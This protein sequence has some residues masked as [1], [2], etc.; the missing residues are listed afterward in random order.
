MYDSRNKKHLNNPTLFNLKIHDVCIENVS[1]QKL[2]GVYID[3]N[4]SWS[5][6]TDHLCSV[7]SSKISLLKQL[8]TYVPAELQKQFYQG[9]ILFLIDYGSNTWGTNSS[10]NIERLTKLRKRAA[11]IIL[12]VD[13]ATPSAFLFE[14]LGWLPVSKRI[15]Y[16]KAILT[17]K[18]L[19]NL[20]PEYITDLLE[21]MSHIYSVNLR[22]SENGTIHVP[23]L[24]TK[25]YESSFLCSAP[26][27]WNSLP[28]SVRN[29]SSLNSFKPLLVFVFK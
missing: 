7:I 4:L 8:A 12:K 15:K 11:R 2:L 17:Y 25:L 18:A 10:A 26:R 29:A 3:K 21:P 6:H 27:L 9:Y 16:N 22:S 28:H 20:T 5:V 14:E 1:K 13:Y 19:N 24:R 23:K